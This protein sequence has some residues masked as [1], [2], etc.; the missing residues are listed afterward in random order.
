MA[1]KNFGA[2]VTA[3][4]N[5]CSNEPSFTAVAVNTMVIKEEQSRERWESRAQ[6]LFSCIGF[7]VGYGNFWRF[8]YVCFKNGGGS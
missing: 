1:S 7:A 4:K 5:P 6:F 2:V 8:P 3:T